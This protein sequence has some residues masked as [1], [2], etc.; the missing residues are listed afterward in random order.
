MFAPLLAGVSISLLQRHSDLSFILGFGPQMA[1]YP[2]FARYTT[3]GTSTLRAFGWGA[4][5]TAAYSHPIAHDLEVVVGGGVRAGWLH[6]SNGG[7]IYHQGAGGLDASPP[8]FMGI[9][10]HW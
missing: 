2:G 6:I 1:W 10:G 8:L 3:D 4:E 9:R 7:T 5:F